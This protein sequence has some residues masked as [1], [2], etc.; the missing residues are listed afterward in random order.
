[1]TDTIMLIHSGD[2]SSTPMEG[3]KHSIWDYWYYYWKKYYTLKYDTIFLSENETRDYPGVTFKHA[4][5][6]A[7]ADGL[8]DFLARIDCKY[9]E[10]MH[11]DY[12]LTEETNADVMNTLIKCMDDN[13]LRLIKHVGCWAGNPEWNSDGAFVETPELGDQM[14]IYANEQ[15]YLVSHQT[16][17]WDVDFLIS[18]LKRGWDPWTH[19]ITGSVDLRL[20]NLPIHAYRGKNPIE[21]C[22]TIVHNQIR[23]GQEEYFNVD[24]E[25]EK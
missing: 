22:E 10:Y 17:L 1:M 16:S 25:K 20:R 12:F 15:P 19:E 9:V 18:T 11:E 23:E 3:K 7:W 21:Y 4:G 6:V 2:K 14:N 8:I 13:K 24:L 5:N